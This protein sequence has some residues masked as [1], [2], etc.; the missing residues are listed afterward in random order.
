[1]RISVITDVRL[2]GDY[3]SKDKTVVGGLREVR[4][5]KFW[6]CIFS[7]CSSKDKDVANCISIITRLTA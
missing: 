6:I 7:S 2:F 3:T 1:M 4:R 5:N